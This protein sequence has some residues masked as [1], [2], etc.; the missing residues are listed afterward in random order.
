MSADLRVGLIGCGNIS[1]SYLGRAHLF[2]GYEMV[3]VADLDAARAEAAASKHGLRSSSIEDLLAAPDIDAVV[4]LTV[5]TAHHAV[6]C[7]ILDAGKHAY[8]EK[9][10]ALTGA[11][12]REIAARA[13]E[14]GRR[15]GC[16][17]DTFLGGSHQEA[18]RLVDEGAVGRIV[19]G[20]CH[21][22]SA[23]MEHWHPN[24][25][26]FFVH[27]GGPV[28]DLGGYYVA[29][30]VNLVGPVARVAAMAT[31]AG[32]TRTILSQPRAGE[33]IPV[34][35]PTTVHALLEF[36][37]GAVVTFGASWDTHWHGHRNVELY[38]TE[39]TLV[40][41]DPNFFGG[42]VEVL[43]K[44]GAP[45]THDG[46]A[47]PLSKTN[48][49]TLDGVPRA[50]YR[51]IGLADM[52]AAIAEGRPHRC[53]LELALHV[54]DVMTTVLASAERGAFLDVETRC[55]RPAPLGPGAARALL[56]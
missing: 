51:G 15:V 8:S 26:F 42:P 4:N 41:E 55:G 5:P 27:G 38:G 14:A 21:V 33:R 47:H 29:Q 48:R 49:T 52:A 53:S 36:A 32:P 9:P 45:K 50:D 56:A 16:A 34:E 44:G 43:P 22:M 46:A 31:Q 10:L 2:A 39:G 13:A 35:V 12:A 3:A 24:P 40:P 37:S 20:T 28:L 7:A 54:V 1:E 17:P 18:R 11:E 25:D 6:T 19:H 23:G 30:L